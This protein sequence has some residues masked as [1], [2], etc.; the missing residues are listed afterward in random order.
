MN[1][2]VSRQGYGFVR[3][4]D[5]GAE[6]PCVFV[7]LNFCSCPL[8]RHVN[9]HD[10]IRPEVA[11]LVIEFKIHLTFII[12]VS[13][14]WKPFLK[15]GFPG[16]LHCFTERIVLTGSNLGYVYRWGGKDRVGCLRHL[17]GKHIRRDPGK[18]L[19]YNAQQIHNSLR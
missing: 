17:Y 14:S 1:K 19:Y 13:A 2:A 12:D 4:P 18:I 7:L 6:P 9:L 5:T 3:Q 11:A 8:H 16:R 10:G 15:N